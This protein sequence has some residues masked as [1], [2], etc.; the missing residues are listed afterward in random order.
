MFSDTE[1]K[2]TNQ[3]KIFKIILKKNLFVPGERNDAHIA[4]L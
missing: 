2:N 3:L 4:A 1:K